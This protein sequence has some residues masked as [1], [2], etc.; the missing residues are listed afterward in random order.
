M[1][2]GDSFFSVVGYLT[3][4]YLELFPALLRM[5]DNCEEAIKS[6]IT[7]IKNNDTTNNI[8]H[9]KIYYKTLHKKSFTL[10]FSIKLHV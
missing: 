2:R 5:S 3:H 7:S 1:S 6:K 9:P 8:K 4:S 10:Q